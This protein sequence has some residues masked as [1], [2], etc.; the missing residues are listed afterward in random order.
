MEN[1]IISVNLP[2]QIHDTNNDIWTP[3][4]RKYCDDFVDVQNHS[5]NVKADMSGWKIWE[6]TNLFHDFLTNVAE[7]VNNHPWAEHIGAWHIRDAWLARYKEGESTILH[8]HL[9]SL[10]SF[11]YFLK[12]SEKSSPL[13][14]EGVDIEAKEGRL[15]IFPALMMH[16]V[17]ATPAERIIL[18]GNIQKA[19]L[20]PENAQVFLAELD[21]LL[22]KV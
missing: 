12:C 15:V 1:K 5:T 21:E 11:V 14:L 6:E 10:L 9:P 7:R 8:N 4:V 2:V 17:S 20:S 19:P 18:A 16:N 13:S 22:R 3:E